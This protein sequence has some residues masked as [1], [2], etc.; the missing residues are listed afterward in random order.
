MDGRMERED[1]ETGRIDEKTAFWTSLV[2]PPQHQWVD[3]M[4]KG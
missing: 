3:E 4:V 1:E 2:A